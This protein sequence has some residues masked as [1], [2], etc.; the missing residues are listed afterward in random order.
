LS[1]ILNRRLCAAISDLQR[2]A[3]K[4]NREERVKERE[5]RLAKLRQD[6]PRRIALLLGRGW[7]QSPTDIPDDMIPIDPDVSTKANLTWPEMAYADIE[8]ECG[9]CKRLDNW[10]ADQQ[11]VYFETLKS[12]PYKEPRLCYDCRVDEV[13]RKEQARKAAGHESKA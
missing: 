6:R 7:I 9:S 5:E 1:F 13:R 10:W 12:S 2:Y 4:M 11:Q 8:F 3:K